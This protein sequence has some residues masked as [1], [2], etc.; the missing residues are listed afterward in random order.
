MR[1]SASIYLVSQFI[2]LGLKIKVYDPKAM[3][4]AKN[5]YFKEYRNIEYCTNKNDVLD[6]S[7]A[8]VLLTEWPEFRSLDLNLLNKKLI[9]PI[10][11]D[12]RN[13]F[14]KTDMKEQ[15]IKYYCI[16]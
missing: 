3:D 11:F 7:I 16:G 9:K 5:V 2:K 4:N 14:K 12:G 13:Q 1:E 15:Q 6:N 10:F 8:L